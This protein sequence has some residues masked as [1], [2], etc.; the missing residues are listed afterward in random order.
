MRSKTRLLLANLLPCL[1][2]AS[3]LPE[4]LTLE[5]ALQAIEAEHPKLLEARARVD[6]AESRSRQLQ[7]E[8]G[9]KSSI[10]IS[11]HWIDPYLNAY[12]SDHNDSSILL[13]MEKVIYD[14]GLKNK[15]EQSLQLQSAANL[16]DQRS[17]RTRL[18]LNIV[19]AFLDVLIADANFMY[20]RERLPRAYLDFT[21]AQE[22]QELESMAEVDVAAAEAEYNQRF[23]D[24]N[25]ADNARR[26]TRETLALLLNRPE[27]L[28]ATLVPPGL[29]LK[30]IKL[31]PLEELHSSLAEKNTRLRILE[32]QSDALL[33]RS[34][35]E[36]SK[37]RP[38]ITSRISLAEYM[39]ETPGR[40]PASAEIILDIPLGDSGQS[41]ADSAYWLAMSQE[42]RARQMQLL[43]EL[44]SKVTNTWLELQTLLR[45]KQS[46]QHY[47]YFRELELDKNRAL[48]ELEMRA[49]LGD[50]MATQ[51]ES[52]LRTLQTDYQIVTQIYW[53]YLQT[54]H[55]GLKSLLPAYIT[56]D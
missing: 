30:N 40:S 27:N 56:G 50:S 38:R 34:N 18:R 25:R 4:P 26:S 2:L 23:L 28:P 51:A 31:P 53:L 49:T 14:F 33:A 36:K 22:R 52:Q 55:E 47:R 8:Y 5:D 20:N 19:K 46:D 12:G 21:R 17:T 29:S 3:A 44:R 10:Q 42:T 39:R 15:M 41:R 48:Y 11:A 35:A 43:Y 45:Q 32:K 16:L 7:A 1:A 24:Y 13:E 9:W 37:S 54:K 6:A